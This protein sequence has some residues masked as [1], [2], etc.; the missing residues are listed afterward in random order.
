MQN[1]L[2]SGI[3]VLLAIFILTAG[4][5]EPPIKEPVVSV[6]DI[7]LYDVSFR[8]M[9]VNST[10]VIYNPNPVGAQLNKIAFDVYYLD[11]NENYL[12]HGEKSDIYVKEN[13]NTTVTIPVTIGNIPAL[14]ALGSFVRKGSITLKVNGSAFI[15]VKVT[16]FEKRFEKSRQFQ[17]T[18]YPALAPLTSLAG[19]PVNITEKLEQLGGFLD[20][21]SG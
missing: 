5:T 6:Q 16:S 15:D 7:S 18:D 20:R 9:T 10:I 14:E 11:E 17:A 12:G 4:C 8:A 3:L 19:T 13:G 1:H 2:L 21:V